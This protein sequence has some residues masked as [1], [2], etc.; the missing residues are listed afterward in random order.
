MLPPNIL[1]KYSK[2][3][4]KH[5]QETKNPEVVS[6]QISVFQMLLTFSNKEKNYIILKSELIDKWL[7]GIIKIE[8]VVIMPVVWVRKTPLSIITQE[9]LAGEAKVNLPYI[10]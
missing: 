2:K 9:E 3:D 10:S 5:L 8:K 7:Q 6:H 4:L 1:K